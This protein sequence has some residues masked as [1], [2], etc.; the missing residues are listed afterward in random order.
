MKKTSVEFVYWRMGDE[1]SFEQKVNDRLK[2]LWN[3]DVLYEKNSN[4]K[5]IKYYQGDIGEKAM[6]ILEKD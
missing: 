6:I 2:T 1:G 5:D 3:R 4:I